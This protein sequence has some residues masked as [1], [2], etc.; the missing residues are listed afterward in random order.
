MTEHPDDDPIGDHGPLS[1]QVRPVRRVPRP[2]THGRSNLR[3]GLGAP[4]QRHGRM[5]GRRL[6]AHRL[7]RGL[8]R[9]GLS[10]SP[11]RPPTF[12]EPDVAW[13]YAVMLE[14]SKPDEA[15]LMMLRARSE[16]G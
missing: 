16:Y 8:A 9:G 11:A 13:G 3:G 7:R 10:P 6:P 14:A 5:A 15:V 2:A 1:V 12:D 4:P